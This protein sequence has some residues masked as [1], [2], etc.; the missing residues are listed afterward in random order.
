MPTDKLEDFILNHH[1]EFNDEAPAPDLFDR[2]ADELDGSDDDD[3]HDPLVSFVLDNR[4]D[5]DDS[6]PPP[7]VEAALFASLEA[8]EAGDVATAGGTPLAPAA[9]GLRLTHSRRRT[10]LRTL[11][12][13]ASFLLLLFAAFTLG[14]RAGY[15][16]GA[17]DQLAGQLYEMNPELAET[18]NYFRDEIAT[19]VARVKLVNND[20]QLYRDLEAIDA[21]TAEIRAN[22][23]EVPVS[24]RPTLVAQLI[25][26]Y[27]TK[28]DILLRIQQHLPP[29][30]AATP[31]QPTDEL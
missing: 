6:T 29:A 2:I 19:Q 25:D 21:A 12:I 13:A 15:S 22:L 31:Q 11:G 27:R 3:D 5:F 24:Q 7:R 4:D 18:E 9:P 1:Q 14:N 26:T 20:P 30:P 17:E 16:A 28:L 10:V 23:L 8:A